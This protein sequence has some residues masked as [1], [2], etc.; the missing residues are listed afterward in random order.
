MAFPKDSIIIEIHAAA[1]GYA[2]R[3]WLWNESPPPIPYRNLNEARSTDGSSP[4]IQFAIS[5]DKL[6]LKTELA[7]IID[8]FFD[9]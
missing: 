7:D 8:N 3:A 2:Y 6:E 5:N 9:T 4:Q 1:D